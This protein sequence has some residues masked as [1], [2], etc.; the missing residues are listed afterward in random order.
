MPT[1][2]KRGAASIHVYMGCTTFG[3]I[4]M[5]LVSGGSLNT[6]DI[7]EQREF[8]IRHVRC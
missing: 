6:A 2:K 7:S 1:P 8:V 5:V 3:L 4:E